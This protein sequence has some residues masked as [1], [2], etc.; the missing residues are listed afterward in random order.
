ML[1]SITF[2]L[3]DTLL[4]YEG[5]PLNWSL[6]YQQALTRGFMAAGCPGS[7]SSLG[8]ASEILARHNTRL[9][10][11][12]VEC[13]AQRIFSEICEAIAVDTSLQEAISNGFFSYFQQKAV[14]YADTIAA[15]TAL[16][17]RG[18]RIGILTDVAYGMP[19]AFV[20]RDISPFR[21]WVDVLLTSVDVGYRKPSPVGYR[22]L[23]EALGVAPSQMVYV[24]NEEKDILGANRAGLQAS[25]LI[26]RDGDPTDYGQTL[27]FSD[28][29]RM[30]AYFLR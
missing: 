13:S 3:G 20:E 23:A 21:D 5:V 10:P 22:M 16:K 12:E 2:D 6:H 1:K 26:Q 29:G 24:G 27:G 4:Y 17:E 7:D 8:V 18:V 25:V 11:R 19:K 30:T 28:L 14:L 15:L 9:H